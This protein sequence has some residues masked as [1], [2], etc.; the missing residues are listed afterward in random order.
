MTFSVDGVRLRVKQ[1]NWGLTALVIAAEAVLSLFLYV[2]FA[3]H[4]LWPDLSRAAAGISPYLSYEGRLMDTSGNPLGGTGEPYCFRF[5]IYDSATGGTKLWPAGSPSVTMATTTDG[6]FSALVGQA[7]ALTYNFYDSDTVYLNVD[8]NT[9]TSTCSGSWESLTPRQTIAASGYAQAAENVYSALLKTDNSANRVNIGAGTGSA[10]PVLLGLDWNNQNQYVGQTC[11]SQSGTIWY[12]SALT[13]ALVCENGI[14]QALSNATSTV[15]A[16]QANGGTP[17]SA[18]TVFFSN[19]NGVSWGINGQT[20]TASVNG[21]ALQSS[22]ANVFYKPA[23]QVTQALAS[24]FNVFPVVLSNPVSFNY[25][26]LLNTISI[27]STSFASTANTTYSYNQAVTFRGVLYSK[28]IGASSMS[29][30]SISSFSAGLTYSLNA[31][32][33]SASNTSQLLTMGITYPI[34]TGTSTFS[35]TYAT[36]NLSTQAISTGNFTRLTG[37]KFLDI[38]FA[39][40]LSAGDYWLA[41]NA[42]TTQTTQGTAG[43]S[44]VRLLYSTVG[45]SQPNNTFAYF[46][47]VNNASVV[48]QP[49]VGSFTTAGGVSTASMGFSNISSA[50]SHVVPYMSLYVSNYIK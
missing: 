20:V 33:G 50:A 26:R 32:Y 40:S 44:A 46:G 19:G 48:A 34:S 31:A 47:D 35:T 10:S 30:A 17:I 49:G 3:A 22:Y 42:S 43:L 16:I 23:T 28:N 18:G 4:I 24:T 13:R 6:V 8:V 25:L 11:A 37:Y 45:F 9:S 14:I 7:D 12:N 38:P 2:S 15:A 29:L 21:A 1:R 39:G 41:I 27:A 36:S 5:S